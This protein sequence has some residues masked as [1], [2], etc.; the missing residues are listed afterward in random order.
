MENL[1][2]NAWHQNGT[3]NYIAKLI[4]DNT[5]TYVQS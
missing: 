2:L 1:D 5:Y 3:D 4:P